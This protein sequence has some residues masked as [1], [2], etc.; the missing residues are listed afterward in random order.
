MLAFSISEIA[1]VVAAMSAQVHVDDSVAEEERGEK[2]VLTEMILVP[3]DRYP[4]V[5]SI[6]VIVDTSRQC[7]RRRCPGEGVQG[8][9]KV[10]KSEK[11][12]QTPLT[13]GVTDG[14][15]IMTGL[16]GMNSTFFF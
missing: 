10:A 9:N 11:E 8:A 12:G 7:Q 4:R 1:R 2:I 15:R 13:V 5:R 3:V 14:W 16:Y 6:V